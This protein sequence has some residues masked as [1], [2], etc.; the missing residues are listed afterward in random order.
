MGEFVGKQIDKT[1]R[2]RGT[3]RG[4]APYN[5]QNLLAACR[6]KTQAYT[7]S[8]SYSPVCLPA[9]ALYRSFART[10]A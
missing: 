10:S 8:V 9:R 7:N 5:D 1:A 3:L 4:G 6:S 2:R